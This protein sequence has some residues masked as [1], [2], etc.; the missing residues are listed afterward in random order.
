MQDTGESGDVMF[1]S[2]SDK[3]ATYLF[4]EIQSMIAEGHISGLLVL[5]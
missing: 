2:V 1:A 5:D 3:R 4:D